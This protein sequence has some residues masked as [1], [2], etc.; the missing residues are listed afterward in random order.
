[1]VANVAWKQKS[2]QE[3]Q[4]GVVFPWQLDPVSTLR[5]MNAQQ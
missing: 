2:L 3:H 5:E 4:T 1:M